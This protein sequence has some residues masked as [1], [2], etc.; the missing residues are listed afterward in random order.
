LKKPPEGGF[1]AFEIVQSMNLRSRY[2]QAVR[3]LRARAQAMQREGLA[4]EAIARSLHAERIRL[5]S[6]FK[7]LTPEPYRSRIY[8]RTLQVYGNEFGPSI[9]FLRA[10]GKSWEAIIDSATRPG[11][12]PPFD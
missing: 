1:F 11:L 9:E 7:E 3:E 10:S 5:A 8:E 6:H 12:P 2:E 4:A